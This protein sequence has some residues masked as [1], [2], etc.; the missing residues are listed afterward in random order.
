MSPAPS[1]RLDAKNGHVTDS[2][3]TRGHSFVE[4][5]KDAGLRQVDLAE[6]LGVYQSWV[7]HLESGQRRID[8]VELIELGRILGFD[9]AE[10]VRR[11]DRR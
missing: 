2:E 9:P 1:G 4:L 11:L 5:R 6:K 8:V 10:V 7:T 3:E